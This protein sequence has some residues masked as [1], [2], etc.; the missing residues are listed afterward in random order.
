MNS[1]VRHNFL[2]WVQT[3]C[4]WLRRCA[5]LGAVFQQS[6]Q[7]PW[8]SFLWSILYAWV[9]SNAC[10]SLLYEVLS[11]YDPH[12][13]V[14]FSW[15]QKN[16]QWKE[17]T[18]SSSCAHVLIKHCLPFFH[19][20]RLCSGVYISECCCMMSLCSGRGN[21]RFQRLIHWITCFCL[22]APVTTFER[23][24]ELNQSEQN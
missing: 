13:I 9:A 7:E 17:A 6:R 4:S 11:P 8:L 20:S 15:A 21:D 16:S 10:L 19:S 12:N 2:P 18:T 22:F 14:R 1:I 3:W 5:C 23:S 24:F